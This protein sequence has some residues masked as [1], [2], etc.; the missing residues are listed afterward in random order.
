ML[1]DSEEEDEGKGEEETTSSSTK[2]KAMALVNGN[3]VQAAYLNCLTGVSPGACRWLSF[4]AGAH[5]WV[6]QE[7]L[8]G[9]EGFLFGLLALR[10]C[11]SVPCVGDDGKQHGGVSPQETRGEETQGIQIPSL[12]AEAHGAPAGRPASNASSLPCG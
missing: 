9:R 2:R 6:F 12:G 10:C 3:S 5:L 11:F 7:Q 8:P 4:G 1:V